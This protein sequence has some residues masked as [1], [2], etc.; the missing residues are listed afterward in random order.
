MAISALV[1]PDQDIPAPDVNTNPQIMAWMMDEFSKYK[2]GITY[3]GV[4]TGKPI[5]VG[6][7]LGRGEAT[8]RGC[9]II[10]RETAKR[11][12]IDLKTATA[13]I[14]GFGNV[15]VRPPGFSQG[16]VKSSLLWRLT[17]GSQ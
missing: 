5:I 6:G 11:L 16:R 2:G 7:S 17:A 1:G 8:G 10:I 13:A 12:G 4:V 9:V 15:G 3:P 14:Q